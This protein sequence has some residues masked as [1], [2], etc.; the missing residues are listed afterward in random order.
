MSAAP[1]SLA[2]L[3]VRR[4]SRT[5]A[6]VVAAMNLSLAAETEARELD[7]ARVRAGVEALLADERLG[8]YY[9][10]ERGGAVV[11]C[12]LVTWEWSDWRN[13]V[14]WWIQSVYVVPAERGRGVFGE[15]YRYVR[16]RADETRGVCGLRLYVDASNARAQAVY[17]HLGM[18]RT[19][20][21]IYEIDF[22]A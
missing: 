6:A 5:D 14:F 21:Q 1:A 2:P 19:H 16:A 20:Y 7:P 3:A 15:L 11:G 10:A 18:R 13:G 8:L 17:A 22:G 4:A 12:T 9:V